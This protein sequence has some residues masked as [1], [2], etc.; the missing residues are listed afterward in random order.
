MHLGTYSTPAAANVGTSPVIEP[1]PVEVPSQLIPCPIRCRVSWMRW[2]PSSIGCCA[3]PRPLGHHKSHNPTQTQPRFTFRTQDLLRDRASLTPT[4][5]LG[6]H[7][8]ATAGMINYDLITNPKVCGWF[9]LRG[10]QCWLNYG[11]YL[12]KSNLIR[13]R[14]SR[15]WGK[16]K[17]ERKLKLMY[18][19]LHVGAGLW[20]A[21]LFVSN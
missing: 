1:Q 16:A 9:N 14:E 3:E 18:K 6:T 12:E 20:I 19:F 7:K 4:A 5:R 8:E 11:L 2:L 10:I 17:G 15:T 21:Q 13:K